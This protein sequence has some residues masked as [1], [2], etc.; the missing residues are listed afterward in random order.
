[1]TALAQEVLSGW[2]P[3][4]VLV[5]IWA[6]ATTVVGALSGHM[7]LLAHYPPLDEPIAQAFSCVSGKQEYVLSRGALHV[8][9][10]GSGLHIA[11]SWLFRPLT[12]RGIP[13]IPWGE[14]RCLQTQTE[15][16]GWIPRW[17]RFE[18][19]RVGILFEVGGRAGQAIEAGLA[20]AGSA[21]QV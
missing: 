9:I 3:V 4:A 17:S 6:L 5:A 19:P 15:R 14:L 13:C 7:A 18:I 21:P 10:G 16:D 1:M 12:H 11:P 2:M 8:G 20:G